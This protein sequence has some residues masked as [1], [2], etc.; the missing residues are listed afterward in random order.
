MGVLELLFKVFKAGKFQRIA[1]VSGTFPSKAHE[2]A[3]TSLFR[4]IPANL[5][6]FCSYLPKYRFSRP[7]KALP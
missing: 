6:V 1:I 3:G 4:A 7:S 5:S 2:K